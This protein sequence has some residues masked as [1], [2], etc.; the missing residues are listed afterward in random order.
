M[1]TKTLETIG[2]TER[3]AKL[4]VTGLKAWAS[5]AREIAEQARENRITTYKTLKEMVLLWYAKESMKEKKAYF[6]MINPDEILEQQEKKTRVLKESMPEL[7]WLMKSFWEQPKIMVYEGL[8]WVKGL[9]LEF[10]EKTDDP[11]VIIWSRPIDPDLHKFLI[12]EIIPIRITKTRKTRAI[13]SSQNKTRLEHYQKHHDCV[14]T[15]NNLFDG[16]DQVVIYDYT[17]VAM[18]WYE[19]WSL[20]AFVIDSKTFYSCIAGIFDVAFEQLRIANSST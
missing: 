3:Q 6:S 18:I 17:K 10:Q 13:I 19:T 5:S 8:E 14:T 1:I 7:V 4:Y 12:N 2:M 20:S 9:F 15:T 11:R 16:A